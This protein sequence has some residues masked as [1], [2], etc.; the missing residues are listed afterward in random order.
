MAWTNG[1]SRVFWL[2]AW[3]NGMC[4]LGML[5][6]WRLHCPTSLVVFVVLVLPPDLPIVV[7]SHCSD[8]CGLSLLL[9]L[10]LTPNLAKT[11]LRFPTLTLFL[12]VS[13]LLTLVIMVRLAMQVQVSI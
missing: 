10:V 4:F 6:F 12:T 1:G 8:M 9:T 2:M 3:T 5:V 13:L 11:L 7:H